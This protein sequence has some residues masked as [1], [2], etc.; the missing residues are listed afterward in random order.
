ME[1]SLHRQ[2]KALYENSTSETEAW[3]GDF[4]IDVVD[5]KQE[6]LIEIQSAALAALREKTRALLASGHHVWIVKPLAA[7]KYLVTRQVSAGEI[8][9][10][11]WSPA[12]ENVFHLFLE[13]VHFVTVFP[14]P[15]LTLEVLLTIQEEQRI[16]RP[17]TRFKGKNYRVAD[18]TLT[19]V[20]ERHI[21][22]TV[23]D[24]RKLLP[25]TL[26]AEFTTEDLAQCAGIPRWLAQKTAY[27]LRKTDAIHP[28]GKRGNACLY[29]IPVQAVAQLMSSQIPKAKKKAVQP[30]ATTESVRPVK[31]RRAA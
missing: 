14:H 2:L 11:R 8:L 25:A 22:R 19:S 17:A 23:E 10:K 13:L 7:R 21:L 27:C 15:A 28:A 5:H 12:R 9:S 20:E 29:Q 1:T 26:P 3:V 6:R 31:K 24:L 18:R 30:Q 4:R 16:P